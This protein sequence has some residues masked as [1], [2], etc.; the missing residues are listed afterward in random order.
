MKERS[1]NALRI[2]RKQ[3]LGNK[4]ERLKRVEKIREDLE[5][6]EQIY[7]LRNKANLTQKQLAELVGTSQSDISRLENADYDGYSVKILQKI[8]EAVNYRVQIKLVPRKRVC[9]CV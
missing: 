8:A 6:A 1:T 3:I 4:P 7:K 5:I 9:A 2:L